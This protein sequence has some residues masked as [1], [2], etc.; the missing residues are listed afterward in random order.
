ME[1]RFQTTIKRHRLLFLRAFVC[2]KRCP[3]LPSAPPHLQSSSSSFLFFLITISLYFVAMKTSILSL[4]PV[5][6]C[7]SL[8]NSRRSG[9][10][11]LSVPFLLK[12]K[13]Y[14]ASSTKSRASPL[15]I[16]RSC[17][18]IT[19]KPSSEFRKKASTTGPDEKLRA[20]REIFLKPG[21]GID[22]YIVPSED[23]HQV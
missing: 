6:S 22:A 7:S 21:I 11:T 1:S 13:T 14:T 23:A 3:L 15:F 2:N 17:S 4:S 18:S 5:L 9:V 20:L 10:F 12:F 8:L 19:A 16:V